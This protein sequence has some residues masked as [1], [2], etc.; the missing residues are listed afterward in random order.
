VSGTSSLVESLETAFHQDLN[1][2]GVIGIPSATSPATTQAAAASSAQTTFDGTTLTLAQPSAF[3][4]QI[5]GFAGNGTL[6]GSDQIDLRGINYNTVHSSFDGTSGT[7]SVND[8]S[9]PAS[10][11]FLGQYSQDNFHFADDGNGGTLVVASTSPGQN[12]GSAQVVS[13]LAA[14]DTF[15]FAPNFG[16][17]GLANFAPATDTLQFSKTA[18]AD[19]AALQAATHDDAGGNAVITDA[20]HDTITFQHVT[21]AQLLAHQSDF[22]FV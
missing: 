22:H 17:V 7:L 14:Q 15:V 4:G 5:V 21:T 6:A 2:D 19:I 8:G 20:A 11:H 13:N 9:T 1:G 12:G 16:Q 10:L 18:F 3:T